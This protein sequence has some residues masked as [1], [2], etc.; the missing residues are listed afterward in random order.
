MPH[1][2]EPAS[3]SRAKCRACGRVIAK[4][5]LRFGERLPNP[6]GDGEMTLWFHPLCAAFR[7]PEQ[8]LQALAEASDGVPERGAL[9]PTARA[10]AEHRRLPRVNGAERSPSRQAKCRQCREPIEKGT[11][12]IRLAFFEDGRFGPGGFVHLDC[13]KAYFED[14]DALEA[15]LHFSAEM[16]DEERR[17]LERAYR[18]SPAS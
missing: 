17:D 6:Y 18:G 9:E 14:H 10:A 15:I 7:R 12:R 5:E 16:S 2:F 13:R 1:V 11:W 8:V 4:G 3:S